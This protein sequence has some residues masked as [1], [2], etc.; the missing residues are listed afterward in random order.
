MS[1]YTEKLKDPRWQKK[2]LEVLEQNHWQCHLC[3]S[4][5]RTLHVHHLYY[6]KG[7]DP[8]EYSRSQLTV[9]CEVCHAFVHATIGADRVG[10]NDTS[11]RSYVAYQVLAE[12]IGAIH[13]RK[14]TTELANL[15]DVIVKN[16]PDRWTVE[17][18]KE[19]DRR[20]SAQ[21]KELGGDPKNIDK[22]W[23]LCQTRISVQER[24]KEL[25]PE[26]AI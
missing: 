4:K 1:S 23:E 12:A 5:E 14:D 13:E 22:A 16:E 6:K 24:L 19:Y 21:L 17:S 3:K 25:E 11:P 20:L 10:K 18:L 9:L 26:V 2:R 8:W 15:Y 7:C